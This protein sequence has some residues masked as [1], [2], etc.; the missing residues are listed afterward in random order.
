MGN[1]IAFLITIYVGQVFVIAV[2]FLAGINVSKEVK[3]IQTKKQLKHHLIPYY[4]IPWCIKN[5]AEQLKKAFEE[6]D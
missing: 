6:L 3:V 1:L 5:A 2:V 4:W